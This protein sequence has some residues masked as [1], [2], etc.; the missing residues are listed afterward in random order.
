MNADQPIDATSSLSRRGFVQSAAV[1]AAIAASSTAV[2]QTVTPHIIAQ[3]E[4]APLAFIRPGDVVLFQGD[5]ITDAGRKRDDNANSQPAL[6]NGYAWLAAA[7]LLLDRAADNLMIY[8]RGV[9]GNKVYQLDERWD[10]DCLALKPNVVSILI[11]VNDIWH[12]LNGHYDG[13]I[14]KYETDYAAL[15]ER[16][17]QALPEVRLVV[18]EPFVLRCGAVTDKWFP[19]F[20]GYRASARKVA[21]AAGA[22]F[23]PFQTMFD[24]AVKVATP[25]RWAH[26]GV[27]PSPDGAA[28]MAHQWLKSVGA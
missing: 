2:A 25:E 12:M 18:C 19:E 23:V 7:S 5:S 14:E 4:E 3:D 9:S 1:A 26:D 28:F 6:G 15:L 10:A 11:G 8:N 21:D 16:T 17:K 27:H 20:D 13:T 24:A 22:T